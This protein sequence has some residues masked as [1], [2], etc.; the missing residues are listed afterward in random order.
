MIYTQIVGSIITILCALITTFLIPF[1]KTK[2]TQAQIEKAIQIASIA[3]NAA[4][5]I[6]TETKM[7]QQ[8]MIYVKNYLKK[9]GIRLDE[10]EIETLIESEVFKLKEQICK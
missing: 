10:K 4:E 8:K 5:Q 2:Y 7:G 9:R 6:F 3:V 1:L